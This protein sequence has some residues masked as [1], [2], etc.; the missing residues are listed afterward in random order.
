[1]RETRNSYN[2]L[3]AKSEG[4][5]LGRLVVDGKTILK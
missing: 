1:M 5:I 4:K 3:V 2:I